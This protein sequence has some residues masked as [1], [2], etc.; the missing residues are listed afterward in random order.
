VVVRSAVDLPWLRD[1]LNIAFSDV[2]YEEAF[3]WIS[4][5]PGYNSVHEICEVDADRRDKLMMLLMQ[6]LAKAQ[7]KGAVSFFSALRQTGQGKTM[8]AS[9]LGRLLGLFGKYRDKYK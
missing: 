2:N 8:S 5:P 4:S 6:R 1:K 3:E 7:S 9:R